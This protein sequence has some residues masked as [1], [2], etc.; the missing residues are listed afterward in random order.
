[1]R[2]ATADELKAFHQA[3][4]FDRLTLAN[5]DQPQLVHTWA[6]VRDL[7]REAGDYVEFWVHHCLGDE[8]VSAQG[9]VRAYA[10]GP[11]GFTD[12]DREVGTIVRWTRYRCET[13]RA[14]LVTT[15]FED[16]EDP[17]QDYY[18]SLEWETCPEHGDQRIRDHSSTGGPDPYGVS[19]LVCGHGVICMGPGEPNT[20]VQRWEPIEREPASR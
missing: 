17:P 1:M 2:T 4:G 15:T 19:I 3:H 13:C 11:C 12:S 5:G 7:D 8:D 20:I 18:D 10:S 9:D 16:P 6:R 14:E